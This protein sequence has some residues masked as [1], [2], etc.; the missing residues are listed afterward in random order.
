LACS[1]HLGLLTGDGG[2]ILDGAVDDLAIAGRF[3][4]TCVDHDLD[5]TGNL[6]DI[7]VGELLLQGRED[8]ALVRQLQARLDFASHRSASFSHY[9]SLPDFFAYRTR[10]VF[11]TP[12]RTT[13]SS[14]KP[15]RVGFLVS[16]STS[17]TF[18]M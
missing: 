8:L 9:R 10:T 4:D 18:E 12:L 7:A 15:T 11:L 13:S 3:A 16:G 6:V 14:R 5:Q 2:Q 17:A 1:G